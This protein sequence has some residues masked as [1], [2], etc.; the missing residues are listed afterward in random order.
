[1]PEELLENPKLIP[2]L[3]DAFDLLVLLERE[4]A[5]CM[6]QLKKLEE[7]KRKLKDKQLKI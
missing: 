4:E 7:E 1:M 3:K 5:L 6:K 2:I